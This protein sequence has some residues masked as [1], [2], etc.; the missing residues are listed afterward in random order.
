VLPEK[1]RTLDNALEKGNR[2]D[3]RLSRPHLQGQTL[4]SLTL[5]DAQMNRVGFEAL[6]AVIMKSS[7]FW[8]T[9][10]CSPLKVNQRLGGTRRIHFQQTARY[11]ILVDGTL[12]TNP[13]EFINYTYQNKYR[14]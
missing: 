8:D 2:E 3:H 10:P 13:V 7:V 9:T 12:Q 5:D 1:T 14:P 4:R 11:Y 6:T